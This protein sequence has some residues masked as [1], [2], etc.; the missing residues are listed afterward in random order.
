MILFGLLTRSVILNY[1]HA[2]EISLPTFLIYPRISGERHGSKMETQIDSKFSMRSFTS[3]EHGDLNPKSMF[4]FRF[5]PKNEFPDPK[6]TSSPIGDLVLESYHLVLFYFVLHKNHLDG[7]SWGLFDPME[8][9]CHR[10]GWR[11]FNPKTVLFEEIWAFPVHC[12]HPGS[13]DV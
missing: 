8:Y 13:R 5:S 1:E 2:G 9:T 4:F 12:V 6:K 11:V 10:Y 3:E 7:I